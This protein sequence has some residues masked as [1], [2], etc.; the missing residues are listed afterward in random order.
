MTTIR[1]LYSEG[2][3]VKIDF[4]DL[5]PF[6]AHKLLVRRRENSLHNG[7]FFLGQ[8]DG[9]AAVRSLTTNEATSATE[10]VATSLIMN[11]DVV[12]AAKGSGASE[13]LE[14]PLRSRPLGRLLRNLMSGS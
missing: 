8:A 11:P 14:R 6:N 1:M 4:V 5:I 9:F 13:I 2:R 3:A 12:R 10:V 7:C